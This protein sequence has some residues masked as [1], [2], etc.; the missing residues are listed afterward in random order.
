MGQEH[1]E[2]QHNEDER[3]DES[4]GYDERVEFWRRHKIIKTQVTEKKELSARDAA[5]LQAEFPR[6]LGHSR[7]SSSHCR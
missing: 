2:G 4:Q 5:H 7:H 3:D 6:T 1:S